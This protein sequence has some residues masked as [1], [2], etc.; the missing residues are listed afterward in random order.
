MKN[1]W[2]KYYLL[3]ALP[4]MSSCSFWTST[5]VRPE[6]VEDT[7]KLERYLSALV[8]SKKPPGLSLVVVRDG[9]TVYAKGF[10]WADEPRN[11]PM[12]SQS[13]C[14][15][16]SLTKIVTAIAILQLREEGKLQLEDSVRK[17][18]TWFD[19]EYPSANSKT[20]TIQHL[21]TH[22]SGLPDAGWRII[23][24]IHHDYDPP[25]NQSALIQKVLPDFAEL[26]YEPGEDTR[27]SNIDYMVL[28]AIIEKISGQ[29][30]EDFVRSRIMKPLRMDQTDFVYTK[31]MT[32]D[33]AAG[34][35]PLFNAMTLLRPFVAGYYVREV[36]GD[37]LWFERIYTDQ[38]PPTGLIGPATDAARL[39]AAYLN[40][41]ELD[42]Q[43]ILTPASISLMTHNAYVRKKNDTRSRHWQ[44]IG[45]Q[46]Y[47]DS[48]STVLRHSGGGPGFSTEMQLCPEKNLGI[49][50]FMN[51]GTCEG[52]KVL[53]LAATVPW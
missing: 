35:H 23:S 14:H 42:G 7:T 31:E 41:G 53:N 19:V 36:S 11:M 20:V 6:A 18:L 49:V 48:N 29:T 12:T 24:W 21:L 2:L 37:R 8:E 46:V 47:A 22:S 30:Y 9:K 51:D 44:G 1:P 28:G 17:Y 15:W 3:F 50:L 16:W 38:T 5:P 40:G 25:V 32:A 4:A 52:W 34:S 39:V 43:R 26:E 13:V 27:Y 10:G 33:E 45:W